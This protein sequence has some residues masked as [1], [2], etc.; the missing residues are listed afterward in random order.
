MKEQELQEGEIYVTDKKNPGFMFLN[1][2]DTSGHCQYVKNHRFMGNGSL[3]GSKNSSFTDYRL[4]TE[5]ER[6]EF[7]DLLPKKFHRLLKVVVPDYQIFN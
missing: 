4:A 1:S 5:E 2:P 3:H 7:L 6:K